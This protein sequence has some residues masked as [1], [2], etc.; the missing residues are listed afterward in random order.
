[1]QEISP[2]L[3]TYLSQSDAFNVDGIHEA[4]LAVIAGADTNA[5]AVSNA[6]YLLCQYPEYQRRLYDELSNLPTHDDIIDDQYLSGKPF[7]L[8]IVNETLRLYPPVPSGLQRLT[9]PEGA[10]IA[11]RYISGNMVVS[12]PTY[13]LHRGKVPLYHITLML[14]VCRSSCICS[15]ERVYTRALELPS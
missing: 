9:P 2:D 8:G 11:G 3:F 5:I 7:L 12:T 13:A 15:T 1:M 10:V 4:R 6:C 14:T